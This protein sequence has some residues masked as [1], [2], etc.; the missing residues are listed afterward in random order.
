MLLSRFNV[1]VYGLFIKDTRLL[2]TQ[3]KIA[4]KI[5]TKFPGGGLE[6]GESTID[7][8][9][10]ELTEELRVSVDVTSHFYTTDFFVQSA[11][12]DSQVISVYYLIT[13]NEEIKQIGENE[14]IVNG[15]NWVSLSELDEQLFT[16]PID[17]HV[18]RLLKNN[19]NKG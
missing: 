13:S 15:F 8:L 14:K 4:G 3:E 5:I 19:F 2:V 10:R 1:R 11:F 18:A 16:F 9:K 17:K 7:C 6:L 12:D